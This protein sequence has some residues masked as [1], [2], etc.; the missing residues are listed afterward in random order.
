MGEESQ[1]G[2]DVWRMCRVLA[3][4]TRLKML[5]MIWRKPGLTLSV[6]ARSANVTVGAGSQ[7]VRALEAQGLLR[8]RRRLA[9]IEC[10]P[11]PTSGITR[12]LL[13]ALRTRFKEDKKAVDGAFRLATA[14]TH[15]RRIEVYRALERGEQTLVELRTGYRDLPATFVAASGK[16]E[17][18][19]FCEGRRAAPKA[20]RGHSSPGSLRA[21]TRESH[22]VSQVT[23]F[24]KCV[25]S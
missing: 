6:L 15:V 24:T 1:A 16:V 20:L 22:I 23:D 4:R 17:I 14:F 21:R 10:W 18:A 12:E 7:Y 13:V 25:T 8:T 5:A 2:F 11:P 3:N 9:W 19:R